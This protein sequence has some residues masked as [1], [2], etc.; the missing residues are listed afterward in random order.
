MK[1]ESIQ[2]LIIARTEF[3]GL[4]GSPTKSKTDL[5][6]PFPVPA[7]MALR[8]KC[9]KMKLLYNSKS[10]FSWPLCKKVEGK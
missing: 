4:Q 6:I 3:A 2:P 7:L 10:K 8:V 1:G 5:A 9:H